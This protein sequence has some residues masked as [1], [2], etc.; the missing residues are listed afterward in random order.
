M[1]VGLLIEF[2]AGFISKGDWLLRLTKAGEYAIRAV[3]FMAI[4]PEGCLSQRE[5]VSQA[6]GI[7][8]SF[9]SK[10]L[11]RLTV[12]GLVRSYKG[13]AGGFALARP[14]EDITV[15]E[16][17]KAVEGPLALNACL[18]DQTECHNQPTCPMHKIWRQ[19]QEKLEATLSQVT[20]AHL[21]SRWPD[22]GSGPS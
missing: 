12:A 17:V 11:Q 7:P 16:V 15:L 13:A 6:Q 14:A 10:I 2:R 22:N 3:V 5:N 20:F 18:F 1:R 9:L 8:L 4:Q 21:A 19:C